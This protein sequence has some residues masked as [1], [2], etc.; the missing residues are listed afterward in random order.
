MV[1]VGLVMAFVPKPSAEGLVKGKRLAQLKIQDEIVDAKKK[2]AELTTKTDASVWPADPEAVAPKVLAK[3][4][5]LAKL[6]GVQV[7]SFRPQRI[8]LLSEATQLP[9]SV[10]VTGRYPQ[11]NQF[12]RSIGPSTKLAIGSI[13]L[14]SGDE[15]PDQVAAT[16]SV[17]AYLTNKEVKDE[18]TR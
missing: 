1:G 15:A 16:V 8:I 14:A 17:N 3:L 13:Q 6:A 4:T 5:A 2:K 7:S 18:P 12:I 10:A 9:M 11:V